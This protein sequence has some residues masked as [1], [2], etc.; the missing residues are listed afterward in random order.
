[1]FTSPVVRDELERIYLASRHG[2]TGLWRIMTASLLSLM[3]ME[4][5]QRLLLNT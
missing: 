1:M 5:Q 4:Q 2:R 3:P